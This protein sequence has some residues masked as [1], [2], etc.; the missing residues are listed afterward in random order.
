MLRSDLLMETCQL[1]HCFLPLKTNLASSSNIKMFFK[2]TKIL[3]LISRS[4]RKKYFL[5]S[6]R[7]QTNIPKI[8]SKKG[9]NGLFFLFFPF[10]WRQYSYK[11]ERMRN[12]S[13]REIP[14]EMAIDIAFSYSRQGCRGLCHKH[15]DDRKRA[16][17]KC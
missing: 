7:R 16:E 8:T 15:R 4:T 11:R 2:G 10:Q 5:V 17:I 9:E 14:Q 13:W 6:K 1:W 3:L 12:I